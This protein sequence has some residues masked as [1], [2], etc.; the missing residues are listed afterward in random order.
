MNAKNIK[1][2]FGQDWLKQLS[3]LL[4]T[5]KRLN[6]TDSRLSVHGVDEALFVTGHKTKQRTSWDNEDFRHRK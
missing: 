5:V 2:S 1:N 4:P 3:Q 6:I